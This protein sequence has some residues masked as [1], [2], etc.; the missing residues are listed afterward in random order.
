MLKNKYCKVGD[1]PVKGIQS[2][3][4]FGVYV[5]NWETGNFDL[6]LGYLEKI[7]FGSMDDVEEL[8]K[9]EFEIY[10]KRLRAEFKKQKKLHKF[11][12]LF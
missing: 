11:V 5:F 10:T 2:K 12:K 6:D 3:E 4:G 1:R 8:T 7:Y 9:E